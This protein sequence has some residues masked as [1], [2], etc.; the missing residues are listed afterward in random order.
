[1]FLDFYFSFSIISYQEAQL[2]AAL[3]SPSSKN[4]TAIS[5]II[6]HLEERETTKLMAYGSAPLGKFTSAMVVENMKCS[7]KFPEE[8]K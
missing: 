7:M 3:C 6:F 2:L 8:M 1:L 4:P 5:Y